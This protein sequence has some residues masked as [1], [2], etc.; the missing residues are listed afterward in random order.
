[1]IEAEYDLCHSKYN[2]FALQ[3][4]I[5]VIERFGK[6]VPIMS[7][8]DHGFYNIK[9]VEKMTGVAAGTLRVWE[10]RYQV[11]NPDR[12]KAGYR[13]YSQEDVQTIQ[14]LAQQVKNGVTIGQAVKMLHQRDVLRPISPLVDTGKDALGELHRRIVLALDDYDEQK[15]SAAME[16]A[17][18]LFSMERVAIELILPILQELGE[19]WA[20]RE[21]SVAHEHFASNFFRARLSAMLSALPANRE[22]PLV[23]AACVSGEHHDL[24][25]LIFSIYLRRRGF[26]VIYLGQDLPTEDLYEVAKEMRPRLIALSVGSRLLVPEVLL[27]HENLTELAKAEGFPLRN[28]IG[29]RGIDYDGDAQELL[30]NSYISGT[31]EAWDEWLR[32]LD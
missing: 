14:W 20:R 6:G 17:L 23:V 29:G 1:M 25:L 26:R 31:I 16:E 12:N 4:E 2:G 22:L 19:R 21:V 28:C 7:T 27:I 18:S 3:F 13:V 24:G 8:K 30:G 15:A 32:N 10:H 9:A 5:Q 11:I